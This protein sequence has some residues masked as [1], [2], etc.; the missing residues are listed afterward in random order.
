M[1]RTVVVD[2][3]EVPLYDLDS[4]YEEKIVRMPPMCEGLAYNNGEVFISFESASIKY[5]FVNIYP[6]THLMAYPVE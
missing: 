2:E 3:K 1:D 5:R 4:R 6:V